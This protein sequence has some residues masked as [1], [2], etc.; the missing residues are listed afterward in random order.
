MNDQRPSAAVDGDD[1]PIGALPIKWDRILIT[2]TLKEANR[3]FQGMSIAEMAQSQGKEVLDAFLEL[4]VDEELGT[5]LQNSQ[6]GA[7]G[8]VMAA[9]ISSP[10]TLIGWLWVQHNGPW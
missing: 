7:D 4:M 9:L 10:Y 1:L 3:H 5:G 8:G 6:Q 2:R